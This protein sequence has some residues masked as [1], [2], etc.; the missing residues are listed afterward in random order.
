MEKGTE[1]SGTLAPL[2]LLHSS[3]IEGQVDEPGPIFNRSLHPAKCYLSR[4]KAAKE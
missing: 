1:E 3:W 4:S 2:I